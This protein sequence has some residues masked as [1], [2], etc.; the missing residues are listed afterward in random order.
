MN[1]QAKI[2]VGDTITI[3]TRNVWIPRTK[4][5]LD[6]MRKR[7]NDIGRWHDDGGEPFLYGAYSTWEDYT[8]TECIV[9]VTNLKPNW[10][11]WH[12]RPSWLTAGWCAGDVNREILF[13]R[14]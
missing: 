1:K 11:S 13:L 5:E 9:T 2:K 3:S 10:N 8:V 4:A 12:K 6:A 7:D 14:K